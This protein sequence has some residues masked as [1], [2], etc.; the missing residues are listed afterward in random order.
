MEKLFQKKIIFVLE[1]W[2][3]NMFLEKYNT[4]KYQV[5][6][7]M[8]TLKG[9]L[10][11]EELLQRFKSVFTVRLLGGGHLLTL[12]LSWEGRNSKQR[13]NSV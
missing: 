6:Q 12:V 1:S 13:S 7:G 9:H 3:Q 5:A 4:S 11:E 2:I 10:H 8:G